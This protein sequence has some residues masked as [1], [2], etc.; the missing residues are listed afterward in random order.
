MKTSSQTQESTVYDA[1]IE[2]L[3]AAA[4]HNRSDTAPPVA[5]LW[6]DHE[7][8]WESVVPRLRGEMPLL[9]LGE[10]EPEGFTGPAIWL[11]CAI[12]GTLPEIELGD[13]TPVIYL[14]GVSRVR[15][16]AVEGCPKELQPLVE[17][18]YR[19]VIF[20][21]PNGK[22]WTPSAF[23]GKLGV[24]VAGDNATRDALS[25]SLPSLMEQPVPDL[26]SR[27]PLHAADLDAL[28]VPDPERE[29]L[30]WL[31]DHGAYEARRDTGARQAFRSL[32]VSRFG[33]DPEADGELAAAGRLLGGSGPW[34]AVWRRYAEAAHRYPNLPGLLDRAGPPGEMKLFEERSPY[35]PRDNRAE[36][37]RLRETLLALADATPADARARIGELEAEHGERRGWV[38]AELGHSPL[39]QALAPLSGLA[40]STSKPLGSGSPDEIAESYVSGGWKADAAALRALAAVESEKDAAAVRAAVRSVYAEWLEEAALRLQRAAAETPLPAPSTQD[41]LLEG[42]C[43]L[44]TDGLRYDVA[45]RLAERLEEEG[46]S[47][48]SGWRFAALPG[49]TPTA[50]PALSPVRESLDPDGGFDAAISG[51][52]VT[53]ASLRKKIGERGYSVL[54]QEEAGVPGTKS[55]GAAWTEFG[56]LD[57]LGHDRG[58]R[59]AQEIDRA[60]GRLSGRVLALLDAGWPEVRVVTDHGWLLLPGGL[61]KSELPEHLT[62]IRKGRCARLKDGASTDQQT[63]PWTLDPQVRVAVATGISA[64]EAGKEYEHGGLSPQECVVPL[65]KVTRAGT[66]DSASIAGI[67]WIGLRCRVDVEGA[68]EGAKADLRTR[69]ADPSTSLAASPAPVKDGKASL[70]VEDDAREGEAAVLVL[71]GPDWKVLVQQSTVVGD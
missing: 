22:D 28:L 34:A 25:R 8:R 2:A 35:R 31:D 70:L 17:L 20:G 54:G 7:R 50:K 46:A 55:T 47:V 56:D 3:R 32:C 39:A 65:L 33:F 12:A 58:W 10:Y 51:S 9:A 53:A 68:P 49:V 61:P 11:R 6:P 43:I 71:L 13:G 15:L 45:R 67:K 18:Q 59:L 29:L 40:E 4:N 57:S 52:R 1:L 48:E 19:G 44:F 37:D 14:P 42:G 38:W 66:V 41:G 69:A 27:S 30:L 63:V 36:E 24:E 16:R 64:Y 21:H 26:E 23:L 5:V 62:T 60:V